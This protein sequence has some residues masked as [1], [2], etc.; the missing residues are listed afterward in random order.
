MNSTKTEIL[1]SFYTKN[2]ASKKLGIAKLKMSNI[3]TNGIK[4][5]DCY[6][7]EYYKCPQKLIDNYDK[8]IHRIIRTHSKQI[9]QTN[10]ITKKSTIFNSLNEISVKFG[11]ASKTIKDAIDNKTLLGGNLWEY[12]K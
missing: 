12:C 4:F 7:V 8:P 6:Y 3:I 11:Y 5:N 2:S 10:P 1:N 9:K